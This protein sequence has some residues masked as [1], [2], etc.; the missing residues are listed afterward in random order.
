MTNGPGCLD[1]RIVGAGVR[2]V[3]LEQRLVT[4]EQLIDV[5][6]FVGTPSEIRKEIDAHDRSL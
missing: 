4:E 3:L 5:Q 2:S 1:Q 6:P